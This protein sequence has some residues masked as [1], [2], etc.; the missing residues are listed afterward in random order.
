MVA[1]HRLN[2]TITHL[3]MAPRKPNLILPV[4]LSL[5][6]G[7][8]TKSEDD[9]PYVAVSHFEDVTA[10]VGLQFPQTE[11]PPGWVGGDCG[12][13]EMFTG[14]AAIEDVN[15]DGLPD[16]FVPRLNLPDK[17][18]I[19]QAD[20]TYRD[21]APQRGLDWVGG[22]NGAAFGDIDRDGDLDLLVSSIHA[23]PARLYMQAA[24]GSFSEEAAAR[25][26]ALDPSPDCGRMFSVVFADHDTDGDLDLHMVEWN[27]LSP[28]PPHTSRSKLYRNDGTGHFEDVTDASGAN[29]DASM[30]FTQAFAD[31]N[32]DEV[33][34]LIAA[35]DF[36]SSRILLGDGDGTF[37][38]ATLDSGF[39]TDENG[40]GLAVGDIDGDLDLDLFVTSIY[41]PSPVCD[42]SIG[43]ECSGN[44]LYLNDGSGHF[45][46]GTDLYDV[47]EGGWAWG[48]AF[49]DYDL[50]GDLDL[51]WT[52]GVDPPPDVPGWG[53][54]YTA[55][56][57]FENLPSEIRRN[58]GSP[59]F[60]PVGVELGI[61][62]HGSGSVFIPFDAD[63]DGDL[64]LLIT[65]TAGGPVFYRN[66]VEDPH[67]LTLRADGSASAPD[68]RGAV[69]DLVRIEG[70]APIR[71]LIP[72]GGTFLGQRPAEAHFGLGGHEG[73]IHE[74]TI[75]WTSGRVQ[76]LNDVA[77]NQ[78]L[79]I[80]ED[81]AP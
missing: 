26:V 64:D 27:A 30:V 6:S 14:G 18:M 5:L 47:R 44:R 72:A 31:I 62:D 57:V 49:F 48:T 3:L 33:S 32:G 37:T 13:V 8:G 76:R 29:L 41:D 42:P 24:D 21:E 75:R 4:L 11:W 59:P 12:Q 15:A 25:G 38:E 56:E 16:I 73:A 78:L 54:L 60:V 67:Y 34:D 77:P 50:D 61:T 35:G 19:A 10:E 20:G 79:R 1:A 68:G 80:R 43:W 55:L 7:C 46:D 17:M 58:D 63:R 22:S 70:E 52:S 40:M 23:E 81:S 71:R 65:H 74:V 39:G 2:S 36:L 51:G 69:V 45:S 66:E 9:E 28:M 53:P